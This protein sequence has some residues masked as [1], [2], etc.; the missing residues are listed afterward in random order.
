MESSHVSGVNIANLPALA[1]AVYLNI[2]GEE[3]FCPAIIG[4]RGK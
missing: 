2:T 4:G 1:R 3:G